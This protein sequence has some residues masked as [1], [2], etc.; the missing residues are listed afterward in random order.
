MPLDYD[1][2]G[3]PLDQAVAAAGARHREGSDRIGSHGGEPR[4]TRALRRRLR[5]RRRHAL[6]RRRCAR[7][8]TSWASTPAA[9]RSST[10]VDCA[11]RRAAR[12]ARG[13]RP[14]PGHARPQRRVRRTVAARAFGEGCLDAAATS[15]GTCPPRRSPATSTCCGRR[16]GTAKL[17][18]FGASYGTSS[19]RRTPTCSPTEW[20]G[21]C[22]TARWTPPSTPGAGPRRRR[23][24]SRP[25]CGP[26][27]RLASP[28]ADLLPGRHRRPRPRSGSIDLLRQTWRPSRC[29]RSRP[30]DL[31]VGN[32][33]YGVWVPLYSKGYWPLPRPAL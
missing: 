19:G 27:S 16:S 8:S 17:T 24:A 28:T 3:A 31:T 4:R 25:R 12:P 10:P 32:A 29:R 21:W 20:A 9:S 30:R 22:S 1:E 7:R 2:P 33:V 18:Y 5:G 23:G 14:R 26:T 15:P 13:Q 6:R 11:Y